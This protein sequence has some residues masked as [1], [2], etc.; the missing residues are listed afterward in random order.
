MNVN[1]KHLHV[2]KW[3]LDYFERKQ[4]QIYEKIQPNY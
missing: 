1:L 4:T 3:H 2:I